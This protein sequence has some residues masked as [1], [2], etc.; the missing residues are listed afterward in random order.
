MCLHRALTGVGLL[1]RTES[2]D[3][4]V[5]WRPRATPPRGAVRAARA[6]VSSAS[7]TAV[8]YSDQ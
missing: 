2:P 5:P 4:P 8:T 7:R 1:E 3:A 6:C